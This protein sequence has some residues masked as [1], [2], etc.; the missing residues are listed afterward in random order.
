MWL[1]KFASGHSTV[2]TTM[3]RWKQWDS[4]LCPLCWHAIKTTIHV[5][6]CPPH[7]SITDTWS[8][9]L[10]QLKQWLVQADTALA[11]QHCILSTMEHHIQW[12]FCTFAS[13]LCHLTAHDQDQ[14][15]LFGLLVSRLS[16]K[17][18]GIQDTYYSSEGS[19]HSTSL[20]MVHLCH[21]L[22]LFN[23]TTIW[24]AQNQQVQDIH[25]Q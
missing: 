18:L 12:S 24:M 3:F 15:G 16:S 11:I 23:H 4:E 22:I 2:V 21:R 25:W 5:P 6:L 10:L 8:Q 14:I 20:W 13:P 17:W 19:S 1:S 9:Q 7:P